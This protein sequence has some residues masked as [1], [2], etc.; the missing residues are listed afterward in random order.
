M[1]GRTKLN[2]FT[3]VELPVAPSAPQAA[4][5][6]CAS[7]ATPT[8]RKQAPSWKTMAPRPG[9][10]GPMDSSRHHK[11][12]NMTRLL[13][14]KLLQV[15]PSVR[16]GRAFTLVELLVVVAIIALL[17]SILLP[18]LGKAKEIAVEVA[19]ASNMKAQGL[20]NSM[21]ATDNK[22]W[23]VPE[24]LYQGASYGKMPT[25]N[26]WNDSKWPSFADILTDY[27]TPPPSPFDW[28]S[29]KTIWNCPGDR[30]Q[31]NLAACYGRNNTINDPLPQN[32]ERALGTISLNGSP[33]QIM[34][35]ENIH[36]DE[37]DVIPTETVLFMDSESW[38][39]R[40]IEPAGDDNT[41]LAEADFRH[42]ASASL[43][44][45]PNRPTSSTKGDARDAGG[46]SNFLFFDGHVSASAIAPL[47]EN[48][49]Q[50]FLM[51]F[52]NE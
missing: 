3:L 22:G 14:D 50:Q 24:K 44:N 38:G 9:P 45:V 25:P 47:M 29:E 2:G 49:G 34:Y 51:Y 18:A 27:T 33:T 13:R 37:L 7:A 4:L 41:F 39:T 43:Y 40:L 36:P 15:N 20:A 1:T 32:Q 16:S 5:A 11:E 21:Y 42:G 6:S 19:C 26:P 8:Q 30:D 12:T 17:L 35:W 52:K 28:E 48:N 46:R 10:T 23:F 31:V